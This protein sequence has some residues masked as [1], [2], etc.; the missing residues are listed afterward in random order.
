[1]LVFKSKYTFLEVEPSGSRAEGLNMIGSDTDVMYI[2]GGAF[3][4]EGGPGFTGCTF[5]STRIY[6]YAGYTM[7]SA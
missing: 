1:L 4:G 7:T 5:D 3:E 2:C 6:P